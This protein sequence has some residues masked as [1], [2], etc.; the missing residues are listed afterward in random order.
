MCKI[1]FFSGSESSIDEIDVWETL[2]E[3]LKNFLIN[4][5]ESQKEKYY[6][7]IKKALK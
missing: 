7:E 5:F 3:P 1:V 4:H 2:R 6:E